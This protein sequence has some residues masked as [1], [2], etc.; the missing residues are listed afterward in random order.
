MGDFPQYSVI[1]G[2]R[3]D[4]LGQR[5]TGAAPVPLSR[6]QELDPNYYLLDVDPDFNWHECLT[7]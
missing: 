4:V 1:K 7:G 2:H 5:S 6:I 3:T